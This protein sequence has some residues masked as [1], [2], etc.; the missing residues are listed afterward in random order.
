MQAFEFHSVELMH[1]PVGV[2]VV[3]RCGDALFEVG[4]SFTELR[5]SQHERRDSPP[6]YECVAEDIAA[7]VRL[8]VDEISAYDR[9]WDR[10]YPGLTAGLR[11]SGSGLDVLTGI[12]FTADFRVGKSWS[13]WGQRHAAPGTLG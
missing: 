11:L 4:D 6:R 2:V 1:L 13:L 10:V 3:G 8:R 9:L 12:D 5:W 7:E